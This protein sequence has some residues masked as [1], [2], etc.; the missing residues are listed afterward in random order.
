M[1]AIVPHAHNEL[2][3]LLEH[4]HAGELSVTHIRRGL[5]FCSEC[6]SRIVAKPE[7]G[8]PGFISLR[9]GSIRQRSE[10]RPRVHVWARSAQ[11]WFDELPRLPKIDQQPLMAAGNGE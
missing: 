11:P 4:V 2:E 7:E 6:G 10:L 3:T 8:E 9:A 5:G 1:P